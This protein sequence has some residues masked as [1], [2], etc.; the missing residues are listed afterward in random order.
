M[1]LKQTLLPSAIQII[2]LRELAGELAASKTFEVEE[3]D[4]E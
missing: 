2:L 3:G 4:N 1:K